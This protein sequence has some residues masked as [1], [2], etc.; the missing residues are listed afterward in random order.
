MRLQVKVPSYPSLALEAQRGLGCFSYDLNK[1][2][3]NDRLCTF[4]PHVSEYNDIFL[5]R[6]PPVTMGARILAP[7]RGPQHRPLRHP[8]RQTDLRRGGEV[9][10]AV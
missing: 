2:L 9:P 10:R 7:R 5:H 1:A 6:L 4:Q 3:E 8:L